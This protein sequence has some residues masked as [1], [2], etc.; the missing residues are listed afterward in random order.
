MVSFYTYAY[1]REDK[2]PYYIGKGKG[3]RAYEAHYVPVPPSDRILFLKENI[4][5]EEAIKHEVYMIAVFGRKDNNTGILRNLTDGG[6]GTSGYKHTEEHKQYISELYKG[7]KKSEEAIEKMAQS[8]RGK[9]L[10][11]EHRRK[12]GESIKRKGIKPPIRGAQS[13]EERQNRKNALTNF[14]KDDTIVKEKLS[15]NAKQRKRNA[16]GH[17]IKDDGVGN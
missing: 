15:Q 12:I 2:T 16:R 4:T 11:E 8:K 9:T 1:L 7:K 17:F 3:R 10:S 14:Y 5:E 6:D 13:E